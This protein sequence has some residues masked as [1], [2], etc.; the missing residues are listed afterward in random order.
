MPLKKI[1]RY[2]LFLLLA[3]IIAKWIVLYLLP[4][5][6]NYS[7]STNKSNY[8]IEQSS[9]YTKIQVDYSEIYPEIE[10]EY[11]LAKEDINSY[12]ETEM[13]K[14]MDDSKEQLTKDDGFLEWIFG[15]LTGYKMVWKKIKGYFGSDDNEV[16]MVSNKFKTDVINHRLLT[17]LTN[18]QDYSKKRIED[19]YKN[20]VLSVNRHLNIQVA[21][22]KENGY[23]K[24]SIDTKTIPWGKY[25]V[26]GI[27]DGVGLLELTGVTSISIISGKFIGAKVAS[28]IGPKVLSIVT[29]KT[30]T[31]VAG[32][33]ASLFTWIFAPLIDYG[34]NEAVKLYK[35]N[36][37]KKSFENLLIDIYSTISQE[38]KIE[39]AELLDK[40]KK[41][42]Y[43][44]LNKKTIIKGEK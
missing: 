18:I 3:L 28:L 32:K 44:E 42:I 1:I 30:A 24:I 38:L 15:W 10:K 9:R 35:Y 14:Q 4:S 23:K 34:T 8:S 11:Q 41:S 12:I 2:I 5:S 22:L 40:V 33:V 19:Y 29:A 6:K 21:K 39:N 36:D 16:K 43:Q 31:I 13:Q 7:V 37:T 25:T 17:T 27:S 26:S 20:V